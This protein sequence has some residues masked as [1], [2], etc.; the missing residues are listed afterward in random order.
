MSR[1]AIITILVLLLSNPFFAQDTT[2][3]NAFQVGEVL[4]YKVYYTSLLGNFNAGDVEVSV[5]EWTKENA[6]NNRT[7]YHILGTGETNG[8]FDM[9]Y[10]VRDRFESQIDT[11]TLLPTLFIRRTKEGNFEHNDDVFFNR[12]DNIAVSNKIKKSVP[13]DIH[14]I[15][16][17]VFFMRTLSVEDFGPDSTYYINFYLDD[18]VYH[19]KVKY[20]GR[21]ILETE[22]GW[23]PCLEVKPMMAIG[24]I[25]SR[26]YPMTVWITDDKNHIPVMAGSDIVVGSVRMELVEYEGLKHPFIKSLSGKELKELKK[27]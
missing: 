22:W 15:I 16:S 1:K 3:N 7:I 27:H 11:E 12:E 24:E 10:K 17:A 9:F 23:L 14:D 19:S 4:K 21:V 26:K 25:F 18:S 8:F 2:P 6:S 13:E 20:E 5:N